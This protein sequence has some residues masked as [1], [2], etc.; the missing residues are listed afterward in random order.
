MKI[1]CKNCKS[2]DCTPFDFQNKWS[3]VTGYK[4]NWKADINKKTSYTCNKCGN[5]FE[6]SYYSPHYSQ[7]AVLKIDVDF[8]SWDYEIL[9]EFK[10]AMGI[11]VNLIISQPGSYT[12]QATA[13][14]TIAQAFIDGEIHG[15]NVIANLSYDKNDVL[16]LNFN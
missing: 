6:G 8:T 5:V 1:T 2:S 15:S 10:T 14:G 13:F 4:S 3:K 16:K 9:K 11:G 7:K 12:Y